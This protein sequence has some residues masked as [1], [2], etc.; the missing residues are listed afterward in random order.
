MQPFDDSLP[1]LRVSPY[2]ALDNT[3]KG[4][5]RQS[6]RAGDNHRPREDRGR[7]Q[8][9]PD[10]NRHISHILRIAGQPVE[11]TGSQNA[12]AAARS[13]YSKLHHTGP[14]DGIAQNDQ[15]KAQT[16][17]N[18]PREVERPPHSRRPKAIV[19]PKPPQVSAQ[20]KV[21]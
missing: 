14:Y 4:R 12:F 2:H 9:D 18:G 3:A 13:S 11:A 17:T 8:S 21:R 15:A 16:P 6:R 10:K 19:D 1:I 5:E 20:T 7:E